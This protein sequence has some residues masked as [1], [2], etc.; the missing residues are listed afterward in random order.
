MRLAD[1]G[2]VE[3]LV[4]LGGATVLAHQPVMPWPALGRLLIPRS[5]P[6]RYLESPAADHQRHVATWRCGRRAKRRRW[7][8][9]AV[10]NVSGCSACAP[11]WWRWPLVS[12][13]AVL[14]LV[15]G[16]LGEL[17]QAVYLARGVQGG[18][19]SQRDERDR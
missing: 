1:D 6:D 15:G 7:V 10:A 12:A 16:G 4:A 19:S 2:V 5:V 17:D 3:P 14:A 13:R 11:I 8:K 9:P 18:Q